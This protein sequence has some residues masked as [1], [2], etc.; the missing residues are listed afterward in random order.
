MSIKTYIKNRHCKVF[1]VDLPPE[2]VPH[3]ELEFCHFLSFSATLPRVL[4]DD[5]SE[6]FSFDTAGEVLRSLMLT[7]FAELLDEILF[8]GLP[9]F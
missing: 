5:T 4:G 2:H 3:S 8:I 9:S 6:I 1:C 7:G